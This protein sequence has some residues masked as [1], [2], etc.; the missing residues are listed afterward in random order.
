LG[1]SAQVQ[2]LDDLVFAEYPLILDDL[3][4]VLLLSDQRKE[5]GLLA[6]CFVKIP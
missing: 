5:P 6:I 2:D 3:D 4:G 1:S